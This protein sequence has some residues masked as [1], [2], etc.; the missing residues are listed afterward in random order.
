MRTVLVCLAVMLLGA[1]LIGENV[2]QAHTAPP[3][4]RVATVAERL[5]NPPSGQ[6]AL[7]L[8]WVFYPRPI[9]GTIR[10]HEPLG[11]AKTLWASE[12]LKQGQPAPVKGEYKNSIVFVKPGERVTVTLVY[13]NPTSRPVNFYVVPHQVVPTS[14]ATDAWLT[15]LCMS[16]IYGAPPQGAWYRTINVGVSP[17]TK[18][19]TKLV[20]V[21][22]VIT[23]PAM[24][25]K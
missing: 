18:P 15:C 20:A 17:E 9:P 12:S 24:F 5:P 16:L 19:G 21:H 10:V 23:D 13:R 1:L 2:A 8:D 7:K 25:P 11:K 3:H 4:L 6:V 22:T 14:K